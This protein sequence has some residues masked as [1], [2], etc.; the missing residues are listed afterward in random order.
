M[1]PKVHLDEKKKEQKRRWDHT[2]EGS[3][4]LKG[5][6]QILQESSSK[7]SSEGVIDDDEAMIVIDLSGKTKEEAEEEEAKAAIEEGVMMAM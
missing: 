1:N 2:V 4:E 7:L 5:S 3:S 6:R